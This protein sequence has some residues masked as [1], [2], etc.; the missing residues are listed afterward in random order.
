[1]LNNKNVLQNV[2]IIMITLVSIVYLN[3]KKNINQFWIKYIVL[4]VVKKV[5]EVF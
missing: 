2:L 3:V 4:I 1:M 5:M